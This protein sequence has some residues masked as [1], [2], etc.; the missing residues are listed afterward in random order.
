MTLCQRLY[1]QRKIL[2]TD[3]ANKSTSSVSTAYLEVAVFFNTFG[4]TGADEGSTGRQKQHAAHMRH[5]TVL[6]SAEQ[7]EAGSS[8]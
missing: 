4:I 6:I 8:Q 5:E 3:P 1:I 2:E 7:A